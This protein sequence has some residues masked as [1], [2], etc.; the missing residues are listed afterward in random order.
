[1]TDEVIADKVYMEPLTLEFVAKIIRMERP[2]AILAG[3][4]GQTGLNLAVALE[5]KGVLEECGAALLG[6]GTD[7]IEMAEDREKF[8]QLCE[9]IGEPVLPSVI[10]E[11]MEE[12]LA[13]AKQIGYPLVLRPAYTLGGT[14]G[15]FVDNEDEFRQIM[16]NAR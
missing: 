3:I 1:M 13:A 5:K 4:G 16:K 15:G 11:S 12:G 8:K 6:T 10:A 7:S 14:G 9:R 2:D